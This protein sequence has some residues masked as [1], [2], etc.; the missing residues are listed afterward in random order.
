M[1][2]ASSIDYL[3]IDTEFARQL[4]DSFFVRLVALDIRVSADERA[5][6]L[7]PFLLAELQAFT[8][9]SKR[10]AGI[11]RPNGNQ[12][13]SFLDGLRAE[14]V[15]VDSLAHEKEIGGD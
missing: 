2:N 5:V 3:G 11:K 4:L 10:L 13:I 12:I 15:T 6:G 1:G 9:S 8:M 7:P 14:L